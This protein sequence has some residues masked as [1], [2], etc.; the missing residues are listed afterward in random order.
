MKLRRVFY[1]SHFSVE[2]K[3]SP[4]IYTHVPCREMR[5]EKWTK[6]K[7]KEKKSVFVSSV[8]D[9]IFVGIHG[10]RQRQRVE[11]EWRIKNKRRNERFEA[12]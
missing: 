2:N 6:K 4:L 8:N 5:T 7:R 1:I 9:D 3:L 11:N 10:G 12:I